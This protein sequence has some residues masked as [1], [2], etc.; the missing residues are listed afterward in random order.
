VTGPAGRGLRLAA[1]WTAPL[2]L[3]AALAGLALSG[4]LRARPARFLV[5]YGVAFAAYAAALAGARLL[6]AGRRGLWVVL[7]AALAFR[8]TL[9]PVEPTLSDDIYRYLWDGR[10]ARAGINPFAHAPDDP[11]LAALRDD[12]WERI[13]H[14]TV[15]TIYP[16]L[17]QVVFR[18]G[19][20][21]APSVLGF[22]ALM[23]LFE[24]GV[25][26]MVW[27]LVRLSGGGASDLL[28]YAW[29]PL[30]IVEVAGSGH[31]D[32]VAVLLLLA[33][34]AW[35]LQ[36]RP[37]LST[38]ALGAGV[39]AKL[40]P[41]LV[42]PT[43]VRRTRPSRLLLLPL[44]LAAGY[45]PFGVAGA[46]LFRG[47]G[48]YAHRW[49]GNDFLFRGLLESVRWLDPTEALDSFITWLRSWLGGVLPLDP[50]YGFTHPQ[51]FSRLLAFGGMVAVAVYVTFK[52]WAPPRE[53]LVAFAAALLL[54][55]VLHPWYLL[56]IAPLLALDPSR[57][58]LL[59]TG[60]VMLS[61]AFPAPAGDAPYAGPLL[62]LEY[63]PVL[64]LLAIEAVRFG[65]Q[66]GRGLPGLSPREAGP[67][68]AVRV[69][70]RQR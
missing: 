7:G 39:L 24:I 34:L 52:P 70:R 30:V 53:L 11:A 9:L 28:V 17:L 14:K 35:I 60:L 55:P 21:I 8:A 15:P 62:Y 1:L 27:K 31:N 54:S 47:L 59:W 25:A 45:L 19:V 22:K 42:L 38:A 23:L 3:E 16:P 37:A 43:F 33:A 12:A 63:V 6:P 65:H 44:V 5:L 18:A 51:A 29:N 40:A 58:L 56:W 10:V 48:E 67:A 2:A 4:D 36:E 46:G 57:G 26:G 69:D 49:E 32:V 41:L 68:R 66:P 50:L 13:N 20:T 61:Y 64:G